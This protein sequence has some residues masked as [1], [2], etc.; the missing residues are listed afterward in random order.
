MT[1]CSSTH[2]AQFSSNGLRLF[3]IIDNPVP[4]STELVNEF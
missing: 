2:Q 3:L 4:L 1:A